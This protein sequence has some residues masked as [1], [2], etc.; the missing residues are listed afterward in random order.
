MKA[1]VLAGGG[2]KAC[3]AVGVLEQL[4]NENYNIVVGTSAGALNAIGLS[5][6]GL[7]G[8]KKLWLDIKGRGDIFSWGWSMSG[9]YSSAPL[10][11]KL[12][13]AMKGKRPRMETWVCA[14]RLEDAQI[15]LARAGDIGFLDMA[16]ASASM[17]GAV[18]PVTYGGHTYADG[19][20]RDNCPVRHARALGA[21]EIDVILCN[22]LG[23]SEW[24]A[25]KTDL[26]PA[27]DFAVRAF[28]IMCHELESNDMGAGLRVFAP[29]E[30]ICDTLDFNPEKIRAGYELGKRAAFTLL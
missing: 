15:C 23:W 6:L 11:K 18:I 4:R 19:G 12:L 7:D 20:I 28:D 16:V 25:P 5:Y 14:V 21:T 2:G 30:P 17:P 29:N 10:R 9:L 26:F 1:L 22:P 8:L 24:L 13:A 27:A 3:F